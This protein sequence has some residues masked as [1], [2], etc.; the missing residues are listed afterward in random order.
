MATDSLDGIHIV[1][2]LPTA[3]NNDS[4]WFGQGTE[5]A[6]PVSGDHVGDLYLVVDAGNNFL[7]WERWDGAAWTVL[8]A[9]PVNASG[10]GAHGDILFRNATRWVVLPASAAT[11]YQVLQTSGSG[12]DPAYSVTKIYPPTS[13]NP[14]AS[15]AFSDGDLYYDTGLGLW[16]NYDGTRSKWLSLESYTLWF[17]R[18]ANVGTGA[19]FRGPDRRAYSATS[20][21]PAYFDGTVVAM[22]ATRSDATDVDLEATAGGT[23]IATLAVG[24]ASSA[25]DETLDGDFSQDDILGFRNSAGSA[26]NVNNTH[27]WC[28]VR[29]RG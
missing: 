12:A 15:P 27:G 6:R 11:Q 17:G 21:F 4:D 19:F 2:G 7:R 9:D 25:R 18:N 8:Q 24:T 16:M 10:G 14:A 1:D 3:T 13:G 29:W 22:S 28:R 23:T 26:G 5:A 20:G